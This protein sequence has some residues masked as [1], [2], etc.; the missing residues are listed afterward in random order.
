MSQLSLR[1]ASPPSV[2]WNISSDRHEC[3][4][5]SYRDSIADLYDVTCPPPSAVTAFK[6]RTT[7]HKFGASVLARG[8]SVGQTLARSVDR[9]WIMSES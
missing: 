5:E 6:S 2:S 8:R 1:A 4:F 9:I 7:A 3:A